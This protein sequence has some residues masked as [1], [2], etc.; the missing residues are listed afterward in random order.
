MDAD[1]EPCDLQLLELQMQTADMKSQL[2]ILLNAIERMEAD[3]EISASA[4]ALQM[5][6]QD[7]KAL[8]IWQAAGLVGPATF[9]EV[10]SAV[11][12]WS[13]QDADNMRLVLE[14]GW[15]TLIYSLIEESIC[16]LPHEN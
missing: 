8:Q 4:S 12:A 11:E 3:T 5:P 9:T 10:A 16:S 14:K 7:P 13:F 1:S 6:P 15:L 2:D